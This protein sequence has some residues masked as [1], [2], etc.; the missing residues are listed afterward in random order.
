MSGATALSNELPLFESQAPRRGLAAAAFVFAV[1]P[2]E[3]ASGGVEGDYIAARAGYRIDHA[4]RHQG[5]RLQVELRPRP[6]AGRI[7]PP[8]HLELVEVRGVDLVERRV[9]RAG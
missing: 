1:D 5:R 4:A 2:E 8:G 7:K 6:Q 9:A 3:L